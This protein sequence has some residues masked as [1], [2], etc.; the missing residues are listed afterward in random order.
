MSDS[1][2]KLA[3]SSNA[4]G[5]DLYR[6]LAAQ[7]PG[8]LV[9][10]PAS[11]ATALTMTWGGAAGE[12]AA[13]MRR[14]L[15]LEGGIGEAG[16]AMAAAGELSRSLQDPSRPVTF[17]IA[18]QLF[19]DRGYE[20][21]PAFVDSTRAAFG[22]PVEVLG[23][24]VSPERARLHI[25][26]WIEEKTAQRVKDLIPP[27]GL[28]TSPPWPPPRTPEIASRSARSF[29]APSCGSTRKGPKPRAPAQW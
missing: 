24:R 14:V 5:C 28:P 17:R 2:A 10:S 3:Y 29:T 13:Q 7:H 16:E 20:L 11:L 18:N 22:A 8:N 21:A 15:H 25:N 19:L 23:I 9:I 26:G 4:F 27:D 1:V 12:T 6:R